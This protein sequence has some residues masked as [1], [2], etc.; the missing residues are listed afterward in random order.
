M[1][2]EIFGI[3]CPK[4]RA[5]EANARKAVQELD[6][7]AEVIPVYDKIAAIKRGITDTPALVIDG[8]LKVSGRIPEV[9]EI[10]KWLQT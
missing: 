1:K 2:I 7:K 3:G 6:V 9:E 8:K 5:T 4:C 10:K